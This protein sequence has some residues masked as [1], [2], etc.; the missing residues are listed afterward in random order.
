MIGTLNQERKE[1]IIIGAGIS[2]LLIAYALKK[3]GWKLQVF[4][5]SSQIGGLIQTLQTPYGPAETAAHSL[6]VNE[7]VEKFFHELGIEL[8]EV[9]PDSKARFIYR[10]GKMRRMPL[11]PIEL[12]QTFIRFFRKPTRPFDVEQGTLAEWCTAYLGTPALRY[13]LAPFVTGVFAATPEELNLKIAFPALVPKRSGVSLFQLFRIR[14]KVK[15]RR[16]RMMTPK[17]GMQAVVDKLAKALK[18][19]IVLNHPIKTLPD[20]PNLILSVPA[21]AVSDLIGSQAPRAADALKKIRYAPLITV[22]AFYLDSA[23]QTKPPKGVGVLIPRHEGLRILGVL[24][25]S[26]A[27]HGRVSRS[28]A[29]SLTIML[30]GTS[31]P[32]ILRV[33]DSSLVDLINQDMNSLFKTGTSA[34][35]LEVTRWEKAIPVYSNEVKAAQDLILKDFSAVPGK[36]VFTNY[37]KEVSIRSMIDALHQSDLL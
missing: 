16:A 10:R 15:K 34:T 25:N 37:S 2:G 24:F 33:S 18:E 26:S 11:G 29:H 7:T 9:K 5:A 22:T 12:L 4:E 28:N 1:A 30:G 17:G 36:L 3:K 31:D 35:H 13:L 20:T 19:E 14:N 8:L 23:F 21:S 32:D 6:M 27:F